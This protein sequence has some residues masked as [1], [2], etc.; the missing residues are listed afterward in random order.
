M[1][2]PDFTNLCL[3]EIKNNFHYTENIDRLM[4]LLKILQYLDNALIQLFNMNVRQ[5]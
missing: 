1:S 2:V 5:K 4:L 3:N